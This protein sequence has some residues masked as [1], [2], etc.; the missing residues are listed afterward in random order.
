MILDVNKYRYSNITKKKKRWPLI[1]VTLLLI[2]AGGILI[3]F[4]FFG[5]YGKLK[6]LFNG[7]TEQR[8]LRV[9]WNNQEYDKLISQCNEILKKD[10]LD[11]ESLVFSGFAYF[12]KAISESSM[13]KKAPLLFNSIKRLRLAKLNKMGLLDG[14]VSY[15]L[16]K[17]YFH[18]GRYYYDLAIKYFED[19]IDKNFNANDVYEYLGLAYSQLG[20]PEKGIENYTKALEYKKS[21]VILLAIAKN[22]LQM[23]NLKKAKEYL[24][25]TLNTTKDSTIEKKARFM[26]ADIYMKE[27]ELIRAEDEYKKIIDI[28]SKSADA[29]YYLGEVYRRMNYPVKARAEWR[30]ALKIDP[31][32][33][34][35]KLRYYK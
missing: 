34:A 32:H 4:Y 25:R 5:A 10:P 33:Y 26:I 23:N 31:N 20:S 29:H 2:A 11:T 13:E 21:D 12:Y 1:L 27:G 7:N 19:A 24:V 9:L 28:D 35:A 17:S 30:E 16:A 14:E 6:T 18:L 8:E 22:Y 15:I 3:S